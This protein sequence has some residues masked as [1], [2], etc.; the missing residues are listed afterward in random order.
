ME[1]LKEFVAYVNRV[2]DDREQ[3]WAGNAFIH[4]YRLWTAK[5]LEI[6]LQANPKLMTSLRAMADAPDSPGGKYVLEELLPDF[7]RENGGIEAFAAAIKNPKA[8]AAAEARG[9]VYLPASQPQ[10]TTQSP[11]QPQRSFSSGNPVSYIQVVYRD[12]YKQWQAKDMV[13]LQR[14]EPLLFSELQR[15]NAHP[16]QQVRRQII[17]ILPTY[18]AQQNS[19]GD[20][21]GTQA[22][23]DAIRD[24][25]AAAAREA[26]ATIRPD[27]TG[28]IGGKVYVLPGGAFADR[29]A[30]IKGAYPGYGQWDKADLTALA[31]SKNGVKTFEM[32]LDLSLT[33]YSPKAPESMQEEAAAALKALSPKGPDDY[34][35]YAL[36]I[37]AV[38]KETIEQRKAIPA[39]AHF[40]SVHDL[41]VSPM[42]PKLKPGRS[43]NEYL[44][45][46]KGTGLVAPE[47]LSPDVGLNRVEDKAFD[48]QAALDLLTQHTVTM[49]AEHSFK[50]PDP[51]AAALDV[52]RTL[53]AT[54]RRA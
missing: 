15:I 44:S 41:Y 3:F 20:P 33:M 35:A 36:E 1:K 52:V 45:K 50:S 4:H 49:D 14:R 6:L 40:N 5:D 23:I 38:G 24:P 37:R 21:K 47:D 8:A 43:Y 39:E 2:Y 12:H 18:Y 25:K 19:A 30:A 32:L 31:T 16:S 51:K 17:E 54:I 10:H 27:A 28:S 34:I 13:E 7:Y 26:R 46:P 29:V 42:I 48:Q 22:F 11:Q 53:N 9:E